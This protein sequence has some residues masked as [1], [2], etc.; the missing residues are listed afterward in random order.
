[1]GLDLDEILFTKVA[2]Y[3]RKKSINKTL[4]D[5]KVVHLFNIK[6]KLNI[7]ANAI[8][9]LSIN[10]FPAKR[11][12]GYKNDNFFLPVNMMLFSTKQL[13]EQYYIYRILYL[14]IQQKL[15]FNWQSDGVV[16]EALS[17]QK[18]TEYAP[19]ILKQLFEEFPSI[20]KIYNTLKE[21][22]IKQ[23]KNNIVAI[24]WLYGKWMVNQPEVNNN[25]LTHTISSDNKKLQQEQAI[26][27]TIKVKAVE[28]LIN[29]TIDKKQQEDYVL[30][31]SF[32]KVE[33]AD[34]FHGNWRDFDG[35]DELEDHSDALDELDMKFTVRADDIVH[36]V[37]H[38]D[39]VENM[40]IAE[41]KETET[42]N[43]YILYNEWNYQKKSYRKEYCKVFPKRITETNIE[44]YKNTLQEYR[45]VLLSLR[46]MLANINNKQQQ[47]KRQT[48][49]TEFDLDALT[50]FYT[51]IYAKQSPNEK[52]YIAQRKRETD[53]SILILLDTSLS[54][55]G[56]ANSNK[57]IDVEKKVS[58]L[59]GEILNENKVDF[60]I[61]SFYSKTRN[62]TVYQTIKA[63]DDSWQNAKYIVGAVQPCGY[64]RIGAALRH[65]T[66]LIAQRSSK[67]KWVILLSDGKP[68]DYDKYEGSYGI[69][70]VK[71]ALKEMHQQN[72][73]SF[74]LA[75]EANAKYY[76]PQ[77]F[78]QNHFQIVTNPIDLLQS[79]VKLYEKIKL[80]SQ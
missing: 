40:A 46:K 36:S 49:G 6:H 35:S 20:E 58:I 53:L 50:D 65:A 16:D 73:N 62:Y 38:S 21:E 41:S 70:D 39:F 71:Q 8:T 26:Q 43:N 79:A 25:I 64:T 55:D 32:E 45:T 15:N 7:L 61:G 22:L 78:G 33:T 68:N 30:N 17:Q 74:A 14:Y 23:A 9:G 2:K 75:I 13:N 57:I 67:N 24:N 56:Y 51:D 19:I 48:D 80:Y 77:M 11:E 10:I 47:I 42:D 72:I 18:A 1:M 12:G 34:E 28:E 69:Y 31:H 54:S 27:T 4:N 52:I 37:Y 59:F 29:V 63:F 5:E 3:F 66:Q 44:L 76:L 60:A